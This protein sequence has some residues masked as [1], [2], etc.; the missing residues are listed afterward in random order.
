MTSNQQQAIRDMR[1]LGVP[2]TSIASELGLSANT[3]KSFCHRDNSDHPG[4]PIEMSHNLC[5]YCGS[6]LA[7]RPGSK[8]KLFCS[9]KCRYTWWNRNRPY[10]RNKNEY[11]LNCFH[12]G[13]EFLSTN[14]KKKFCSRD[15]YVCSRFG[16]GLP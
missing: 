1:K 5:K 12:C 16:E 2:I 6:L 13:T 11:K 9:D 7:H 3:V 4:S 15:C 8:K 14:K 10:Y